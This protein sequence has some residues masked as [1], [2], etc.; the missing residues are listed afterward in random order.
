MGFLKFLI[1]IF[2]PD[3]IFSSGAE[4]HAFLIGVSEVVAFWKPRHDMPPR[5]K[6]NGNPVKTEYHY[7]CFGRAMGIVVWIG[8]IAFLKFVLLR[9]S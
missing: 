3:G 7:Y 2:G 1:S 8:L 6:A 5:Y 4:G 9:V